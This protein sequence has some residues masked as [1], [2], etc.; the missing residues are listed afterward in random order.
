[1]ATNLPIPTQG[2]PN[3]GAAFTSGSD[4]GLCFVS[5]FSPRGEI[6]LGPMS[7][8]IFER[9]RTRPSASTSPGFS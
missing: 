7:S 9:S 8:T 3:L 6:S 2:T 5:M 1:M 4:S